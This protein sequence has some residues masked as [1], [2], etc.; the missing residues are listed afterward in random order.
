M[1]FQNHFKMSA[2]YKQFYS[3]LNVLKSQM[4]KVSSYTEG[5][6]SP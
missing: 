5:N 3:S 2:K 4:S 1:A 6:D